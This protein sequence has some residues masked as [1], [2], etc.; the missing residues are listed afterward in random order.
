MLDVNN[1]IESGGLLLIALIVCAESGLLIGFFLP[2]DTLLFTAG[3]FASQDK[4]PLLG[5]LVV[6]IVAAIV[7]DQ[8]GYQI[9]KKAGPRIF[10]KKDDA[11]F[12]HEHLIRAE[13][14][15]EKHGGKTI[16]MARF[17]PFVRTFAPVVAGAA[18]MNQTRFTIFNIVGAIGWAISVTL[19]GYWLG[20]KV[21]NIDKYLLPVLGLAVI[22]SF[23]PA[24]YHMVKSRRS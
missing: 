10:K 23:G 17:T 15:Y 24:A 3:F 14:F 22:F 19:L 12:K 1:L 2:G 9:G 4:L 16:I 7:G 6:T 11:W 18:K 5:L 21:P 13:K 20:N 8:I